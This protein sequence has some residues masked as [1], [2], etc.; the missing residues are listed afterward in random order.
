[1]TTAELTC[2]SLLTSLRQTEASAVGE[3]LLIIRE[4]NAKLPALRRQLRQY[5]GAQ[6]WAEA[7]ALRDALEAL[8]AARAEYP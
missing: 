2:W 4:I 8:E 7:D 6:M 3:P 5:K 1:M